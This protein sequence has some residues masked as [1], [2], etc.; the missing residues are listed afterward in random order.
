[1]WFQ[2]M[3]EKEMVIVDVAYFIMPTIIGDATENLIYLGKNYDNTN[4]IEI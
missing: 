3:C 1:M 4:D 2:S